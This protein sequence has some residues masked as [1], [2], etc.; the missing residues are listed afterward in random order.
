MNT[1]GPLPRQATG[2]N[3]PIGEEAGAEGL[4]RGEPA[5]QPAGDEERPVAGEQQV[6][7][8]RR[9]VVPVRVQV[10]RPHRPVYKVRLVAEIGVGQIVGQPVE[11]QR[12]RADQEEGR[13]RRGEPA[14]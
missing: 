5:E 11:A 12:G 6:H 14:R 7:Q 2:S 8:E 13:Q 10:P 9:L 3:T 4:G 1:T